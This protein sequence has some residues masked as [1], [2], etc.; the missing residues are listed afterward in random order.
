MIVRCEAFME[1][2]IFVR[3]NKFARA[4]DFFLITICIENCE[5]STLN[6]G[7]RET[8][9]IRYFLKTKYKKEMQW[10][11]EGIKRKEEAIILQ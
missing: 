10:T 1:I 8:N 7:K 11:G 5:M 3:H 2:E 6:R 9:H 4:V